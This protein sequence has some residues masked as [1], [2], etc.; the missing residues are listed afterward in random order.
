MKFIAVIAKSVGLISCLLLAACAG[1][2]TQEM[3]NAR[4][5]VQAAYDAGANEFA[6][7]NLEVAHD[8]LARAE[9]ELELRYFS[10]AYH[11]AIVAKSEAIKAH[12]VAT[13]VQEAQAAVDAMEE[14]SSRDEAQSLLQ[15]AM[16]AAREGRDR[17]AVRL[18]Q[19]AQRKAESSA[20]SG[21]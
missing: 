7:R 18:A 3:S 17:Q 16:N 5:S 21:D 12:T 15:E 13:A 10:M 1:A 6:T 19:E 8:Y 14:G 20:N 9:R 4:Q 2:P 11:D